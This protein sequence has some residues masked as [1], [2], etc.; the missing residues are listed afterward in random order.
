[1]DT[2]A[3]KVGSTVLDF[4]DLIAGTFV[5]QTWCGTFLDSH[6]HDTMRLGYHAIAVGCFLVASCAGV[7]QKRKAKT[8]FDLFPRTGGDIGKQRELLSEALFHHRTGRRM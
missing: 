6:C 7:L 5:T 4:L 8:C 3:S 2:L 1:M